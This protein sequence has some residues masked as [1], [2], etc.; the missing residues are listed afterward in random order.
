MSI[1]ALL[2]EGVA[3]AEIFG[4]DPGEALLP[5]EEDALG[6]V[7]N[8]RRL[9]FTAGRNCARRALAELGCPPEPILRGP[10]HEPVW[11]GG[12]VGSITHCSGYAAAAVASR[13]RM[14]T[15]G[16]DAEEHAPL[17]GRVV[18]MIAGPYEQRWLEGIAEG[19]IHW[20]R[21][22][23]SAK[24]SVFKAWF[25][26]VRRRLRFREAVLTIRPDGTFAARLPP[27]AP[28]AGGR[29]LERFDG[30]YGVIDGLVLTT[31]AIPA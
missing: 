15:V 6:M 1:A 11:P 2:P 16:I 23:F 4:S 7:V 3:V 25:P 29:P 12:V 13:Q 18:E 27:E 10:D 21:V 26:L 8:R 24:E 28:S 22:L 20:D 30:R 9:Q 19:A 14:V 17:P 31:V 5:E